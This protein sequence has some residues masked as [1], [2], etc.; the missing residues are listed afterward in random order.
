[1]NSEEDSDEEENRRNKNREANKLKGL[2]NK[3][4]AL[5]DKPIIPVGLSTKYLTSSTISNLPD[6]LLREKGKKTNILANEGYNALNVVQTVKAKK[7][8]K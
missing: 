3:L 7:N 4:K 1:M 2:K 6:I 5:L 8:K